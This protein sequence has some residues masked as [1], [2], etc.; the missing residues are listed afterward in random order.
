MFMFKNVRLPGV[1][2]YAILQKSGVFR[3]RSHVKYL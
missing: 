1:P 2:R 3:S